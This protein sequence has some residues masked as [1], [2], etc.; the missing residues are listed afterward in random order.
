M[1]VKVMNAKDFKKI[2]FRTAKTY[3]FPGT[4]MGEGALMKKPSSASAP[5]FISERSSLWFTAI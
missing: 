4:I 1:N 3:L 5:F 2:E